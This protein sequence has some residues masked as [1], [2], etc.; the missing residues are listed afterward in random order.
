M[1]K[2]SIIVVMAITA[3]MSSCTAQGQSENFKSDIDS[4]S[5]ASGFSRF[6]GLTDYLLAQG[7]DSTMMVDFPQR[8]R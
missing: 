6:E 7:V 2:L 5:Y 3:L 8:I 1:K 4:L